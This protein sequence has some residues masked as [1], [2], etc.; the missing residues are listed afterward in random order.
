MHSVHEWPA[1]PWLKGCSSKRLKLHAP[2]NYIVNELNDKNLSSKNTV[3][4]INKQ[5]EEMSDSL[6]L[7]EQQIQEY[8]NKNQITDLSLKAQRIYTN[9]VA[10][11]TELAKNKSLR[12]YCNYLEDY[13]VKGDELEG[14][15]VPASFGINNISLNGLITQLIE[16]QNLIYLTRRYIHIIPI[17]KGSIVNNIIYIYPSY[18]PT[19]I[20][21]TSIIR[22]C[23][24]IKVCS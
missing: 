4:F 8:K 6:S 7:I 11:E 5:L 20:H 13:I 12:N 24:S 15:S 1:F 19:K 10:I 14:I 9:I 18:C 22:I 16:I 21:T 3:S 17:K 2:E 23:I